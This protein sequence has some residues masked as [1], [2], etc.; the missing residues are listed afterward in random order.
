MIKMSKFECARCGYETKTSAQMQKHI[1]RKNVCKVSET[2]IDIDLVEYSEAILNRTFNIC[3]FC[4]EV[5]K[6][7]DSFIEHKNICDKET[8]SKMPTD[9]SN[10]ETCNK[11]FFF[12]DPGHTIVCNSA[13]KEYRNQEDQVSE[14]TEEIKEL[15]IINRLTNEEYIRF[16][17]IVNKCLDDKLN[18][19]I[20]R[21]NKTEQ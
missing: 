20:E 7:K 5:F 15:R 16:I 17:Q 12:K 8:L 11:N 19:G 3:L 4:D 18:Q 10:C 9:E 1:N 21:T 14:L 13:L 6:S 2:G